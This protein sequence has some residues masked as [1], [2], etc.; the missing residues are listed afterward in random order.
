MKHTFYFLL[1]IILV[2]LTNCENDSKEPS[3]IFPNRIGTKWKYDN[4]VTHDTTLW[5]IIGKETVD[6]KSCIIIRSNLI[7]S[8]V[9]VD[10]YYYVNSDGVMLVAEKL[11]KGSSPS[12]DLT[13]RQDDTLY[14]YKNSNYLFKSTKVIGYSWDYFSAIFASDGLL[15]TEFV[16]I[17]TIKKII[18]QERITLPIGQ[19]DCSIVQWDGYSCQE[20]YSEEGLVLVQTKSVIGLDTIEVEQR[21]IDFKN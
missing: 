1:I 12:F 4:S 18:A 16:E 9:Y 2:G 17:K 20:Y 3:I 8:N 6:N 11:P 5:E 15:S 14:I 19:F 10:K 7:N 13:Y 21:L